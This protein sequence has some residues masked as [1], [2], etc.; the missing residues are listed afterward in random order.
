MISLLVS[1]HD[2]CLAR[3]FITVTCVNVLTCVIKQMEFYFFDDFST[4]SM[5]KYL[6][7]TNMVNSHCIEGNLQVQ[8]AGV[9]VN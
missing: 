8:E 2:L 7:H 6:S 5:E 1:H 9:N 4:I 3:L